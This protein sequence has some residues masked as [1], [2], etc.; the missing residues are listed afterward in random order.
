MDIIVTSAEWPE[1]GHYGA[2]L[3]D[4]RD[5]TL[6]VGRLYAPSITEALAQLLQETCDAIRDSFVLSNYRSL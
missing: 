4:I 2:R 5:R 3:V 1:N 6:L